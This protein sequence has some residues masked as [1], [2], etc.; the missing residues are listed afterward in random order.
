MIKKRAVN[1]IINTVK[2]PSHITAIIHNVLKIK[3]PINDDVEHLEAL[4]DW[5]CRSQDNSGCGGCSEAYSFD[6][7]WTPPYPETTGYIIPTFIEYSKYT[8]DNKYLVRAKHMGDWEIDIQLPTGAVRGGVGENNYPI[9]FNTGQVI[10]GWMALYR[11]TNITKYLDAAVRAADWLVSIIDEDGKW[12]QFTYN[13]TPHAYNSR[14][15]WAI[16]EVYKETQRNIYKTVSEKNI[17]WALSLEH[18][19]G[20]FDL[21][22]FKGSRPPLTHTIAYTLRGLLESSFILNNQLSLQI[23]DSV[24]KA[25]KNIIFKYN[26]SGENR[27]PKKLFIPGRMDKNWN[28]DLTST[29]LTGD[30]QLTII[31][32]K[33]SKVTGDEIYEK[34]ANNI[35]QQLKSRH[36]LSISNKGIQGGITGSYPIWGDYMKYSYPNWAAKFFADT[37]IWR[38]KEEVPGTR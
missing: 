21:M 38:L 14:V 27:N 17:R 9:V 19:N 15:T 10:L 25:I 30:A 3:Y 23:Q 16:L 31:L 34:S 28:S 37:L 12:K 32:Q 24:I 2:R 5:L 18:E 13:N 20:F 22:I 26:I 11:H 8:G 1:A 6:R 35:I 33:L 4:I 29:C 36:S 7:G